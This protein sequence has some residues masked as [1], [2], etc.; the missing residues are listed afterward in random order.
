LTE[1]YDDEDFSNL[2]LNVGGLFGNDFS[3][4]PEVKDNL[5][6]FNNKL[7]CAGYDPDNNFTT[8][9]GDNDDRKEACF[10]FLDT[11]PDDAKENITNQ[12]NSVLN[13]DCDDN[14]LLDYL[15]KQDI[16]DAVLSADE[17]SAFVEILDG[18][19]GEIPTELPLGSF[20]DQFSK[21]SF[22]N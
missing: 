3:L 5:S 14:F 4:P 15:F 8:L 10:S 20:T 7:L 21:V 12:C 22:K 1:C 16:F 13:M 9:D 6:F 19:S 11:I 17:H 2:E 18:F